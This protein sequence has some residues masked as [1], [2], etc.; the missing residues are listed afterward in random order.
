MN[1]ELFNKN[2]DDILNTGMIENIS[3]PNTNKIKNIVLNNQ[4]NPIIFNNFID[5]YESEYGNDSDFFI[6]KIQ[7]L[8]YRL[9]LLIN[10]IFINK[11]DIT[12]D[13]FIYDTIFYYIINNTINLYDAVSY[14]DT[15]LKELE[16]EL[17]MESEEFDI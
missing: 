3:I 9:H 16:N 15:D 17:P 14:D 6:M 5:N 2:V 10:H 8:L 1:I 11:Y 4:L 12:D 7:D 13:D